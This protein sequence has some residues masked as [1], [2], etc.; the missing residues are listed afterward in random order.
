MQVATPAVET[1]KT[2][3]MYGYGLGERVE[4]IPS[5]KEQHME[6]AAGIC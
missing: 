6:K 4:N 5:A 1:V 2:A 3:G